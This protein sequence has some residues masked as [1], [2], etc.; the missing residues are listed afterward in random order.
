MTLAAWLIDAVTPKSRLLAVSIFLSLPLPLLSSAF[1]SLPTLHRI[2]SSSS[3]FETSLSTLRR[4]CAGSS[5]RK[6]FKGGV[7]IL[8]QST[9]Q[10]RGSIEDRKSESL[11][12]VGRVVRLGMSTATK[13]LTVL[14]RCLQTKTFPWHVVERQKKLLASVRISLSLFM[15]TSSVA[16]NAGIFELV[17][18]TTSGC[19]VGCGLL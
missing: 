3:N 18:R 12:A 6:R 8:H 4:L 16:V 15:T 19:L 2:T 13:V 9:E 17:W 11:G 1:S 7:E 5:Y 10:M 14:L